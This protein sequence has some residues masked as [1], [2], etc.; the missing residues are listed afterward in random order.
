[1]KRLLFLVL[2]LVL[3][4]YS[5]PPLSQG[6]AL[7]FDATDIDASANSGLLDGQAV[8]AWKDLSGHGHDLTDTRGT[9]TYIQPGPGF[10]G[11]PVVAFEP[12]D[13]DGADHLHATAAPIP[14]YP[15]TVFAVVRSDT[16]RNAVI[17]SLVRESAFNQMAGIRFVNEGTGGPGRLSL[18]RRNPTWIETPTSTAFNDNAFHVVTARFV[19]PSLARLYVDGNLLATSNTEVPLPA[20]DRFD[21]GNNGRSGGTTDPY[22]GQLAEVLV[23]AAD[24][25]GGDRRATESWLSQKWITGTAAIAASPQD[26]DLGS[27]RLGETSARTVSITPVGAPDATITISSLRLDQLGD[28]RLR[29]FVG[30][31]EIDP[32]DPA[33][34]PFSLSKAAGD[35]LR[36]EASIS[37]VAGRT[38]YGGKIVLESDAENQPELPITLTAGLQDRLGVPDY[39]GHRSEGNVIHFDLA[40]GAET[41]ITL[42][43]PDMARIQ[44]A[45]DG[46]FRSD[47]S[48]DLFMVRKYDWDP[49]EHTVV[50]HGPYIGIHT[51]AMTLRACKSPFRLQMYDASNTYLIVKDADPE[52]MWSEQDQR[53]VTREENGGDHA[54][55]GFGSGDHGHSSPLDKRAGYDQF[56]VTHGRTC[57]PFFMS[58]AGYGIFLNTVSKETSFDAAGGFQTADQLDYWYMAG[59]FKKVLGL[60]SELTGRMRL[61]P[62]WAYGFML[63]KYGNDHATQ[64][65]FSEWIHRLRD[66]DYPTD[67][68]VFDYGWRGSK[69]APHRW[70]PERFPDLPGMFAEARGLGFHVGLHNNKGTPEAGNGDFTDPAVADAWWHAHWDEVIAPGYG[71]WFWPDEFDVAGDNLMANRAAKVVHERWLEETPDQR[72]MFITRGGYANHH[73]AATWSGDIPNTIEEMGRQ[74]TGALALGMSGYPWCSNDLGGF[75]AKPSDELYIRWVAQFGAFSG[76]MRAHGHDGREPWLYSARAQENLRRYLKVRYRLF[77]YLY[78]TARQGAEEGIPMMRA[79]ALEHPQRPE[80]W[81][82][83]SQYYLGDWLLV[84]PALSTADPATV[85]VWLPPG[86]WHDFFDPTTIYEGDRTIEVE[87]TLDQIPVFV[88][89][90]AILPS[91]PAMAHADEAPLDPLTLDLFPGPSPTRYDLYED[92]G[93]TRRYLLEKAWCLTR[94]TAEWPADNT[95]RFVKDETR[96]ENPAAYTPHLPRA[97]VVRAHDWDARPRMVILGHALV[98]EAASEE[99]LTG[100]DAGWFWSAADRQLVVRFIDDGRAVRLIASDELLDSDQDGLDDVREVEL[101]TDLDRADSDHD[102]QDDAMEVSFGTSPLDPASRVRLTG[103]AL[104]DPPGFFAIYWPS[105]PGNLYQIERWR[106]DD[107]DWSMVAELTA[108]GTLSHFLHAMAGPRLLLRVRADLP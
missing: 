64:A 47:D 6:L 75:F 49:V 51:P 70:D 19:H 56:T 13:F 62:K 52:G 87:A 41:R 61:F 76:L 30:G 63:S 25:S 54:R 15:F 20:F 18:F 46:Q 2:S 88:K 100:M 40:H 27:V 77:P 35:E 74:I 23:Y 29:A 32:A 97:T 5:A 69:F 3:P 79:M 28:F 9:P 53:G 105:V 45:P 82:H 80:A 81:T 93:L 48:P 71:D 38:R 24:V 72:P 91:G 102:D 44:Y 83:E 104:A 17:F 86:K 8:E 7:H 16:E 43:T 99:A 59:G 65:E 101:G 31:A 95:L 78:T 10:G 22:Q 106:E 57:V 12:A 96:S 1:M 21:L 4:A 34:F 60:Y 89:E 94:F 68:Y 50:D 26:V 92:D 14:A 58:T 103:E 39:V 67:V 107:R 55:F 108:S 36:L 11:L 85:S 66:E 90:G 84:A 37:P 33:A 73:F 98:A 42:N